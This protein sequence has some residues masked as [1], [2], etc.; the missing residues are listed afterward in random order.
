MCMYMYVNIMFFYSKIFEMR[1]INEWHD[2]DVIIVY[3]EE[4]A[5]GW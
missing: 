3:G 5:D 1:C 2:R 4:R